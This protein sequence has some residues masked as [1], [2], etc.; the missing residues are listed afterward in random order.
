MNR[1]GAINIPLDNRRFNRWLARFSLYQSP[2]T[3]QT[4]ELWLEQF[5]AAD[6]DLVAR[7]LDSTIFINANAIQHGYRELLSSLPGWNINPQ[8]RQGEWFFVPFSGS[9]GESGDSMLHAFRVANNLAHNRHNRL[10]IHRSELPSKELTENDNIVLVDDF[11]GTGRQAC[12]SWTEIFQELLIGPASKYLVLA[13]A[14]AGAVRRINQETGMDVR[15]NRIFQNR[16]NLFHQTCHFYSQNEKNRI[17]RYCR[18][19]DP[20][21]PRG[22]GESG[23]LVVLG[24]RCPNNSIPIL[25]SENANWTPLFPRFI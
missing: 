19:A 1:P 9:T 3:R 14:T 22:F 13:A 4:I 18:T 15:C 8:Q 5:S 2:V 12:T 24:H 17:L 11:S 7:I 16:D 20:V 25:H 6:R 21:R 23:L 10:F